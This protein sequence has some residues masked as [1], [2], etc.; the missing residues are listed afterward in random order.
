[1]LSSVHQNLSDDSPANLAVHFIQQRGTCRTT[2]IELQFST[3]PFNHLLFPCSHQLAGSL[4]YQ[5]F[6]LQCIALGLPVGAEVI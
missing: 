1:M 2:A 5:T 3:S 6:V 4:I